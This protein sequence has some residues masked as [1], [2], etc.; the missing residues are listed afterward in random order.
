[1]STFTEGQLVRL[2]ENYK[3]HAAGYEF[4][5]KTLRAVAGKTIAQVVDPSG[6]KEGVIGLPTDKLVASGGAAIPAPTPAAVV[7]DDPTVGPTTDFFSQRLDINDEMAINF[8]GAYIDANGQGNLTDV[9]ESM[10]RLGVPQD[11]QWTREET[12]RLY[13]DFTNAMGV[14]NDPLAVVALQPAAPAVVAPPPVAAVPAPVAPAPVAVVPPV[15]API[16]TL[17]VPPAP[18]PVAAPAPVTALPTPAAPAPAPVA[19]A[20]PAAAPRGRGKKA[21]SPAVAKVDKDTWDGTHIDALRIMGVLAP[22]FAEAPDN[23]GA[24]LALAVDMLTAADKVK[25]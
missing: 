1:M 9:L 23:F 15:P 4:Q 3:E 17:P 10:E 24:S 5:I 18:V 14:D 8:L 7:A 12:A 13:L 19:E 25:H 16:A 6:A 22:F 21:T 20:A 2:T 11:R